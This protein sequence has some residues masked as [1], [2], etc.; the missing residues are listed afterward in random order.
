MSTSASLYFKIDS[1]ISTKP[2]LHF[3][4]DFQPSADRIL[5][6]YQNLTVGDKILMMP[7]MGFVVESIDE[8]RSIVSILEDGSTS[9]CLGLYPQDDGRTRLVSRWRPKFERSLATFFMTAL[10]EPGTFIMEQKMLRV[11]RDRVE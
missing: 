2:R 7:G 3:D 5:P 8:P 4:N 10:A 9:W 6:E 11:I 1:T